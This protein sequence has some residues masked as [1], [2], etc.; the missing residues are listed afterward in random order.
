MS[1]RAASRRLV[2]AAAAL[3]VAVGVFAVRDRTRSHPPSPEH[4]PLYAAAASS[5]GPAAFGRRTSC[6]GVLG[7]DTV[8][9]ASPTLPCGTRLLLV[10]R[11]QDVVTEVVDRGGV[12]AGRQFE[13]TDALARRLGLEGVQT[14]QWAYSAG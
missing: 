8:G 7:P 5:S 13:L 3:L 12:A 10:Y 14:I 6:G 11:G 9:V 2:L 4:G 1:S